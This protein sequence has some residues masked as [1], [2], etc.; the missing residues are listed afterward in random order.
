MLPGAGPSASV[1]ALPSLGAAALAAAA[2]LVF[3]HVEHQP[4]FGVWRANV[5][6]SDLAVLAVGAVAAAAAARG[7]LTRLRPAVPVWLPAAALLLLVGAACV[8]PLA[9]GHDYDW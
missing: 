3:L 8:Y 9:L 4:S 6:L 2:P 5:A 7:G 1:A